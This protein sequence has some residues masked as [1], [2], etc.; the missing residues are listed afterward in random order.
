MNINLVNLKKVLAKQGQE[1]DDLFTS[2]V[3]D[4]PARKDILDNLATIFDKRKAEQVVRDTTSEKFDKLAETIDD[5]EQ[6]T[7]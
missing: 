7:Q 4:S 1:R 6:E 2:I 3:G 5:E